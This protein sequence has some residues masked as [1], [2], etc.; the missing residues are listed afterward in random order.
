MVLQAGGARRISGAHPSRDTDSCLLCSWWRRDGAKKIHARCP[1]IRS[2][3]APWLYCAW[4]CSRKGNCTVRCPCRTC[5]N[6]IDPGGILPAPAR[7]TCQHTTWE[8]T[9]RYATTDRMALPRRPDPESPGIHPWINTGLEPYCYPSP[10]RAPGFVIASGS[11]NV[12]SSS[13]V[14]LVSRS[15]TCRMVLFSANAFFASA[16]AAS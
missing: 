15:A 4:R 11:S 14:R 7:C 8:K 10:R 9:G 13:S 5:R 6:S 3:M 1:P 16:A 2:C 12:F